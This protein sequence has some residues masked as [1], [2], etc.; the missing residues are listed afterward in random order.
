MPEASASFSSDPSSVPA[1]R[2]LVTRALADWGCDDASWAAAQIIAE[3]AGNCALHARTEFRV[4]VISEDDRLRLEVEDSSPVRLQPRRYGAE[5]TT[6]RG[7][8]LVDTLSEAWGVDAR[9]T[10]KT[11]WVQLRRRELDE[12]DR[13]DEADA[14]VDLDAVLAQLGGDGGASALDR[15]PLAA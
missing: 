8:R 3:L 13:A 7:L 4:R 5:A 15:L 14:A 6:G 1:A 10:G 11:V 9:E 12:D 2:R